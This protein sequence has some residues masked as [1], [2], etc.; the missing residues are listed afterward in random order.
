MP[1]R[2]IIALGLS[3]LAIAAGNT[4][5]YSIGDGATRDRAQKTATSSCVQ[6]GS[7]DCEVLV[8]SCALP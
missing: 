7:Q 2:T 3:C 4:D 1:L 5:R 8:W 6:T